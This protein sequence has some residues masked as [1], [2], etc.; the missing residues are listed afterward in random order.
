MTGELADLA[1]EFRVVRDDAYEHQAQLEADF[2]DKPRLLSF[3]YEA[4]VTDAYFNERFTGDPTLPWY[5]TIPT[6]G[7]FKRGCA[8]G[9]GGSKQRTR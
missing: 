7:T 6:Y 8:L 2:Y 1:D 3:D 5:E 4:P 9:A